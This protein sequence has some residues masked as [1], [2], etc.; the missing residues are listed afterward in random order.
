MVMFVWLL[1]AVSSG[2]CYGPARHG[3][4]VAYLTMASF[5]VLVIALAMG[6]LLRTQ[7]GAETKR[8]GECRGRSASKSA[9]VRMAT[10]KRPS[11]PVT[12][13]RSV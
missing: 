4:K 9:P 12:T 11:S 10:C 13:P 5:V 6:L 3:R 1:V 2:I 8:A 7:H